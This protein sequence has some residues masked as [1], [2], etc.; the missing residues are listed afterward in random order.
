MGL[1]LNK[2]S[3]TNDKSFPFAAMFAET[4]KD[5]ILN[6]PKLKGFVKPLTIQSL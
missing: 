3:D 5:S 4:S 6:Q 2:A 1:K